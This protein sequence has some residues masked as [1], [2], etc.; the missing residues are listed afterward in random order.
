MTTA[1]K[2]GLVVANLVQAPVPVPANATGNS[3]DVIADAIGVLDPAS[4]DPSVNT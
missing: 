2:A 1:E 4:G 3:A